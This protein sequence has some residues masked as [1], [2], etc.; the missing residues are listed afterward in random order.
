MGEYY[1]LEYKPK[2]NLALLDCY[3]S[4][5]VLGTSHFT[6]GLFIH[7]GMRQPWTCYNEVL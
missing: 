6:A 2:L 5:T 3:I 7:E 1:V 4:S